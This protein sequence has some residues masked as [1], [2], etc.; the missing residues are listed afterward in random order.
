MGDP[1]TDTTAQ[2]DS[3]DALW[4]GHKY[5]LVDDAIYDTLWNKCDVRLPNAFMHSHRNMTLQQ[6]VQSKIDSTDQKDCVLA[7]RKFLF[8]SSRALSQSWRDMYIDDYS[9]F[10]PVTNAEDKAMSDYL[11]RPDVQK[12]LHVE[13]A[14]IDTWPYPEAG[15]DYTKEYDACN[16]END[17][18]ADT[19]SMID[20]YRKIVPYV[21]ITWIYNGDTDPCVSYEGTRTAVKRIGFPELDGGSY[22]PWFYNHTATTLD[23]LKEKAVMF[24]PDLILENT[25][26]QFG[27]EIVN[28]EYNLAFLTVHGSGHMVPQFRPQAALHMLA[29]MIKNV[30][31]LSPLLPTNA[32][33]LTMTDTEFTKAMDEWTEAAKS[34]PYVTN[35][36]AAL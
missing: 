2:A 18:A 7:L 16:W 22:R 26:A 31:L 23:V 29:T 17:I 21:D 1:C 33:L 36:T 28:Y 12:A 10:A 11:N 9:L 34:H 24:G 15:F 25:G 35:S 4:Y 30:N 13:H 27:G 20:F 8:S 14:P 6:L 3:M 32:T 5:G 19:P